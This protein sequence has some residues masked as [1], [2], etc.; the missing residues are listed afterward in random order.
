[1]DGL[2]LEDVSAGKYGTHLNIFDWTKRKLIQRIDLGQEGNV[3]I[4]A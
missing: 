3:K 1:M 2:N 4:Q